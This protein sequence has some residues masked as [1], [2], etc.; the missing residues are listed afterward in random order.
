MTDEIITPDAAPVAAQEGADSPIA[1]VGENATAALEESPA[2]VEKTPEQKRLAEL[3]YEAR[4]AKR[5]QKA[6]TERREAIERELEEFKAGKG[7]A[8]DE[9]EFDSYS[10]YLRAVTRWEVQ[11]EMRQREKSQQDEAKKAKALEET[12]R[13]VARVQEVMGGGAESYQDFAVTVEALNASMPDPDRF[14]GA[15]DTALESEKASDILYYLGKNP[16]VVARLAALSPLNQAREIGRLEEKFESKKLTA[17][18]APVTP[19]KGN[20]GRVTSDKPPTD[21]AEYRKWRAKQK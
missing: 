7:K 14:R 2:K 10:D 17:A 13:K 19:L 3:A 4:E 16:S 1:D 15:L 21:P 5:Q 8:P 9:G 11:Q 12:E 6:E 20:G 18:P